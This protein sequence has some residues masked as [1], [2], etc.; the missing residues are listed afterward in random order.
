MDTGL[1]PEVYP[2]DPRNYIED[3]ETLM[4]RSLILEQKGPGQYFADHMKKMQTF[5]R[6]PFSSVE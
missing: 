6:D 3:K 5:E 4:A 2:A 1:H